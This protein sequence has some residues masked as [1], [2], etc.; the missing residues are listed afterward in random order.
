[1][2]TFQEY[3]A[4]ARISGP[5]GIFIK[6]TPTTDSI[7]TLVER[8]PEL[9]AKDLHCTL[10]YTRESFYDIQLPKLERGA[11]W[12]ATGYKLEWF[13][14]YTK[15]G[16]VI[17]HLYS[18][19]IMSLQKRFF[20]AGFP[21]RSDFPEYKPHVSLISPAK[22]EDWQSYIEEHNHILS[23]H[24]VHLQFTYGGYSLLDENIQNT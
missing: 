2:K 19:Q 11:T 6:L 15:V 21:D 22:K 24:P 9:T 10:V 3:I 14:G 16:F 1:M 5:D 23:T 17:L 18:P 13:E 7:L 20:D 12:D 8:F 4:E